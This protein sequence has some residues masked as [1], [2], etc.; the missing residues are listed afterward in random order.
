MTWKHLP[1]FGELGALVSGYKGIA[2][3]ARDSR[4][5]TCDFRLTA[6]DFIIYAL[7]F[8]GGTQVIA[9]RHFAYALLIAVV[10][11]V[12]CLSSPAQQFN[13][14]LYQ[15]MRWRMIGP[16]RGG[17]TVAIA[18]VPSQPNVFYMAAVNGGVWKSTDYGQVWTPIF[19]DQPTQSIGAIAVAPS[20]PNIIYVGSGEGIQRPDLAV[21]DGVYKSTDG[22][23]TWKNTGLRDGRQINSIVVDPRDQNRVF[24][25]V[26]GHPYAANSER[27]VFRSL[28]GGATWQKVLYQDE[29]TGAEQVEFDPRNPQTVYAVL[30]AARQAPWEYGNAFNGPNSGLFKSSDGGNSWEQLGKG[31]PKTSEGL[32]R[33][34]FAIAPSDP[35]RIYATVA[36]NPSVA[37]IYRSDDAGQS[38]QKTNSETR[39][40]G[41]GDDFAWLAVDPKDANVLYACNTSTYRSTNG[42]STFTAIKGAPG[43]D[44]YHSIW[45]NPQNPQIIFLGADQGATISVNGGETW[46]SW[47]NQ[48]TAQFYHV[49]T[50]N[51]VPDYW[52][53][54]GQQESGSI[55]I[56]SRSDFGAITFRD[57]HPVGAEEYGYIAPDPLDPNIIYGGKLTRFNQAT[58]DVQEISPAVIRGGKYRFDRTAPV[59][60]SPKDP[61][62]LFY[63]AQMLFKTTDGGHSWQ[64]ISPDLTREK[65]GVP[66]NMGSFAPNVPDPG[67]RGVIYAVGPSFQ[68][69]NVIW[70]GTDD[71]YIQVTRDGGKTW[72]NV[73]PPELTA[74]SKVS[75]IE[76]SHYDSVSAYASV[77][78]FR[79]NDLRPYV[80]RT[81]DG[82]KSWQKIVA[83]LP[84]DEAVN[85]V[86]EDPK[87][88]GLLFAATEKSVYVSFDDGDHWQS[89]RLNLPTTSI[90]DVVVHDND[91]VVGTHGRSFWILDNITPLRQMNQQVAQADAYLFAPQLTYRMRRNKNTDTPLPPEVP[92]GQN[93]PD[94]AMIDYYLKSAASGPVVLEILDGSNNVVRRYSST[95][96]PEPVDA[97][98]LNV[99]TY[100]VRQ[101]R[102]LSAEP[103]MHRWVWDLRYPPPDSLDHEYP[104]SAIYKDTPRYPLGPGVLPGQYSERLTVGG[105]SYTQALV[106][107]MD[108]RIKAT[109]SEL[110]QQFQLERKITDG[111][112]QSYEALQQVRSLSAQLKSIIQGAKSRPPALNDALAAVEK[113]AAELEGARSG[114]RAAGG[115][116]GEGG[117]NL[118]RLNS[119][120]MTLLLSVDST[121]ALP[122]TQQV[123]ASNE[124]QQSLATQLARW[125]ELKSKDI[126]SLNAQL[127]QSNL[128]AIDLAA[129]APQQPESSSSNQNED[130]P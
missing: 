75:Q 92:A 103:G 93:P 94:G 99:P 69:A 35:N 30:W 83:G 19:E 6:R 127:Q 76:S 82:G 66:S 54:G 73:T 102:V 112:N 18:G 12:C 70:V 33:I 109:A 119:T 37:G 123:A 117:E 130:E 7:L 48:P 2:G 4:L 46:S 25:A 9:F 108:P 88:K 14:N 32:S 95:D 72:Q 81:H 79:I 55:G 121:D 67:R 40:W 57:W 51:R 47:Y 26:L 128:P 20:N 16:H 106:I 78:R 1:G 34:G 85:S 39:V 129:P 8:S 71:G 107:R 44:D 80:Y 29:D 111:M 38:W 64:E 24:V 56:A 21:G 91:L 118:A 50:D 60:F 49:I 86:R 36:A 100:W 15:E 122:T 62:T 116:G 124:T 41:R 113:K 96:K 27:G 5:F 28:D 43:G 13:P 42:G 23:K 77:F 31:L 52:V 126:P 87:R 84:E 53:Y 65:P 97:R 10:L 45:I 59:I 11:L 22:G 114:R 115:A 125:N 98:E 63:A 110:A 120:L 3:V 89:L 17:R 101:P 61:K 68:D 90:R 105:H 74:W 58:G 104:I